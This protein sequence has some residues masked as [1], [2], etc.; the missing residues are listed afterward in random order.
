MVPHSKLRCCFSDCY[1]S[2]LSDDLVDFLFVA[3]SCSS[4]LSTTARLIGD[5][6]V[7]ALKTFHPPSDT[8]GT[9][10]DISRHTTKL[11]LHDSCRVSLCH[12][13]F[14][15]STL[16][17]WHFGDSHF[18]AV[19]DGIVRGAHSLIL[20][21]YWRGKMPLTVLQRPVLRNLTVLIPFGTTSLPLSLSLSLSEHHKPLLTRRHVQA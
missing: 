4:S 17:K 8:A 9:H 12:K 14:N 13:K 5:V 6:L 1:P 18:L 2:V 15:D 19:H 7:S 16:T 10:A 20:R 21:S 3:L 11:L